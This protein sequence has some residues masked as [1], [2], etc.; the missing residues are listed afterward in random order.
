MK[1]LIKETINSF[2][3]NY[4]NLL[5]ICN[6]FLPI[7]VILNFTIQRITFKI[8][9][10]LLA[11]T[12]NTAETLSFENLFPPD[13]I[14]MSKKYLPLLLILT[15]VFAFLKYICNCLIVSNI[16]KN[17][18]QIAEKPNLPSIF[19]IFLTFALSELMCG[20]G[21]LLFIIPG[22]IFSILLL[23]VPCVIVME[24]KT[25]F[26]SLDRSFYLIK[27]DFMNTI[28]ALFSLWAIYFCMTLAA[29]VCIS[30]VQ[31]VSYGIIKFLSLNTLLIMVD[32]IFI[33]LS[34]FID[35]ALYLV[36]SMLI[37]STL[38]T[39]YKRHSESVRKT[40]QYEEKKYTLEDY[41][42]GKE[43]TDDNEEE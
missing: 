10:P 22:I 19:M 9:K 41:Y 36:L 16:A 42:K 34:T 40:E 14:Q 21:F 33:L 12:Q 39:Q 25:G 38:Y 32:N 30:L 4:K 3:E 18:N 15:V 23:M 28:G 31:T 26:C 35:S 1:P 7:F 29:S 27:K 8:S 6:I 2:K 20:F 37:Q 43:E 17:D 13:F 24:N 5:K 11:A